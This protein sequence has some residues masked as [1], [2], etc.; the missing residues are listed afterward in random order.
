MRAG[1]FNGIFQNIR[2]T[3][4]TENVSAIQRH[5]RVCGGCS[6]ISDRNSV[7]QYR[8]AVATL[9]RSRFKAQSDILSRL[10]AEFDA[11]S[12]VGALTVIEIRRQTV[13]GIINTKHNRECRRCSPTVNDHLPACAEINQ[14]A[15]S[16]SACCKKLIAPTV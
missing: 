15:H 6:H 3:A 14:G 10:F 9:N 11:F 7:N 13:R 12:A 8:Y 5:R 2:S 1:F 16:V 4:E